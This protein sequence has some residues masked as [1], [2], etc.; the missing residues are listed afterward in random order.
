[1][2]DTSE[3]KNAETLMVTG[4]CA[5]VCVSMTVPIPGE[6]ATDADVARAI[7]DS[8]DVRDALT[9]MVMGVAWLREQRPEAQGWPMH[10]TRC[11]VLPRDSEEHARASA[12]AAEHGLDWFA[13]ELAD[14]AAEAD[15][16]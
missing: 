10:A 14:E 15:N 5:R 9:S 7:H 8:D 6:F 3:T 4:V 11:L 1:M 12:V 13:V 2:S 16:G